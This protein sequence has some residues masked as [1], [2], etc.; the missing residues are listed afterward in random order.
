MTKFCNLI[1]N[2]GIA[3]GVSPLKKRD[4]VIASSLMYHDFDAT[5]FGYEYGQV[6]SMPKEFMVNPDLL[7]LVKSIFNRL[8][9]PYV[10]TKVYSGD[11]FVSSLDQL[12][13]V[14][15]KG[16]V[17]IEMEGAAIAHTAI[18]AGVD[19][20][21]L[22]YISDIIGEENQQ[23]DYLKFEREMSERSAEVTLKLLENME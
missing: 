6:P 15:L 3:G 16:G 10:C 1:I 14:D 7:V 5:I 21:V 12:D 11:Q 13:K 20:L 4:S 23:E 17:A 2:S 22:R 9:L 18:K 8:K 19:F